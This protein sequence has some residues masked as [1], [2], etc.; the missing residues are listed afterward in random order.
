[1]GTKQTY[2]SIGAPFYLILTYT[3]GVYN[4][5]NKFQNSPL[6]FSAEN[7]AAIAKK[8]F[9]GLLEI[10]KLDYTTFVPLLSASDLELISS[11]E[12][13]ESTP[14]TESVVSEEDNYEGEDDHSDEEEAEQITVEHMAENEVGD[15]SYADSEEDKSME[16]DNFSASDHDAMEVD[17]LSGSNDVQEIGTK[18]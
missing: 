5:S 15:D 13:T 1:M 14:A 18:I 16:H 7:I 6:V 17:S 2:I 8:G 11:D 4:D 3:T 12:E 10:F 9:T